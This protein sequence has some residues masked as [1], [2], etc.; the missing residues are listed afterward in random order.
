MNTELRSILTNY[1]KLHDEVENQSVYFDRIIGIITD[2]YIDKY[3]MMG[4]RVNHRAKDLLAL[5]H[6]AECTLEALQDFFNTK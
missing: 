6:S 4:Q 5:L 2:L 1:D 3:K